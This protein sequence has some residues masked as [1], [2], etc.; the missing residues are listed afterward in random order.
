[1]AARRVHKPRVEFWR[2]KK[3]GQLT[4][5]ETESVRVAL[6]FLVERMGSAQAVAYR[7][8]VDRT[9]V[10]R[11]LK[12]KP[13]P[14]IAMALEVARA[15]GT[16]VDAVLSGAFPPPGACPKCWVDPASGER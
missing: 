2:L 3:P 11:A 13:K 16:T 15:A 14:G 12:E 9:A 5:E 1:M 6:E 8:G 4:P 10:R 7:M